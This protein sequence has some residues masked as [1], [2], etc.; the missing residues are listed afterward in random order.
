MGKRGGRDE[1]FGVI[2]FAVGV[3]VTSEFTRAVSEVEDDQWHV[4]YRKVGEYRVDTGQQWAEVRRKREGHYVETECT[5]QRCWPRARNHALRRRLAY[6]SIRG[7]DAAAAIKH[8]CDGFETLDSYRVLSTLIT[9]EPSLESTMEVRVAGAREHI[10]RRASG[11][12]SSTGEDW[13]SESHFIYD[14]EG[15]KYYTNPTIPTWVKSEDQNF[16]VEDPTYPFN[17]DPPQYGRPTT[18]QD[19]TWSLG[20]IWARE[21]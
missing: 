9:D 8:A 18:R 13:P 2:D 14:G 19:S 15:Y 7:P 1:R 4:L 11:K 21:E 5:I 17:P 20:V 10:I 16:G 6:S 3:D 12:D